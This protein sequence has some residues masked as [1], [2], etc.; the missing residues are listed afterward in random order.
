MAAIGTPPYLLGDQEYDCKTFQKAFA[1]VCCAELEL[2]ED[3]D[4]CVIC[5]NGVAAGKV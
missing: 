3:L 5:P 2:F 4:V 1:L